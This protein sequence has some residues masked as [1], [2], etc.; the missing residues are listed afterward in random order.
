MKLT[1]LRSRIRNLLIA[2]T[3]LPPDKVYWA[4]QNMPKAKVP[5]LT[6]QLGSPRKQALEELRQENGTTQ[7]V[8][9][10]SAVLSLQ[11][12]GKPGTFAVDVLEELLHEIGRPTVVDECS[13]LGFAF[14]DAEPVIDVTALLGNGQEFEPRAALD[15]QVGYMGDVTD[16]GLSSIDD[17]S[18]TG[19]LT[20]D[21][22]ADADDDSHKHKGDDDDSHEG[23]D[24]ATS[25]GRYIVRI[26]SKTGFSKEESTWQI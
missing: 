22:D 13:K 25:G 24:D 9:P 18:I 11:Y 7:V 19:S 17:V 10:M 12:F 6:L 14:Y 16:V 4:N 26:K 15:L 8:T 5:F 1:D 2:V 21:S 23:D 3:E 20:D